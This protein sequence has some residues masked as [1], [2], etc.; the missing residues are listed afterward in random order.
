MSQNGKGD[1]NRTRNFKK[2]SQGYDKINW[3]NKNKNKNLKDN[4]KNK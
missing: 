3:K 4:K 1:K 2:F